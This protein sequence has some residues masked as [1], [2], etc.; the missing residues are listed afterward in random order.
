MTQL[1]IAGLVLLCLLSVGANAYL[2][3]TLARRRRA[4]EEED[5]S[6]QLPPPQG[7][8]NNS[9]RR[10]PALSQDTTQ[11][12]DAPSTM[13]EARDSTI[14]TGETLETIATGTTQEP[15][16]TSET[17]ETTATGDGA[18]VFDAPQSSEES[19][20]ATANVP[21]EVPAMVAATVPAAV[22][23]TAD[24]AVAA[25]DPCRVVN[26]LNVYA[27]AQAM[28]AHYQRSSR[29][30]ELRRHECFSK[31]VRLLLGNYYDTRDLIEFGR[32][33]NVVVACIALEALGER[34][35]GADAVE[36]ILAH[37]NEFYYWPG[38]YALRALDARAAERPVLVSLLLSIKGAWGDPT[39]LQ[40]LREF[41]ASRV[42]RGE[43]EAAFGD[44]LHTLPSDQVELL[45]TVF[46]ALKDVLPP[47]LTSEFESWKAA[48]VDLEFLRSFGRVWEFDAGSAASSNSGGGNTTGDEDAP[49]GIVLL[50]EVRERVLALETALR[51]EPPRSVLLVGDSG[52]GKT[53]LVRVLA[54]RLQRER[55]IILEASAADVM[56]GQQYIGQ[57]EGRVQTLVREIGG[58]RVLWVVPNF[59]EL[60]WAGRHQYNPTGLLDLLLPHIETGA[61]KLI[62][63]TPT[64][65]YEK[66]MQLRPK[67]RTSLETCRV[68]ALGDAETLEVARRWAESHET[69]SA[70][71]SVEKGARV[72]T[73]TTRADNADATN[74][75]TTTIAPPRI[76]AQTLQEAFQLAKQYLAD[77]A[78][79]GN[80]LLLLDSTRRRLLIERG[81]TNEAVVA[82]SDETQDEVTLDDLLVTLSQLTGLPVSI[83]DDREGLDLKELRG[84]FETRVL[85]QPEA[86]ECLVERV[87]MIKAG[88]TDPTRPQGV[89]LFVGPT[90]TGKTEIAKTLAEFLF[91]SPERMIRL[92]MSEFQTPETLDRILGEQ[93]EA[94]DSTALVNSIRKQPF[95]VVLLDEFEKAHPQVWD[96][97]LQVFD[98]GRLTDRR[99]NTAD[100]RHCVVI[101]TSNL[102]ATLPHG[103]SI[104]FSQEAQAQFAAGAVE[105]AVMRAFRR[106][107]VN[108]IDRVV[109]F[110]PL[111][112]AVMRDL[113]RK[114]LNDV[115][116]RR[117]L[118]TRQWAVEW[119]ESAID[120]LLEKGFT[121]DL[122]ARPLKR[123]I[124][125]YLLSPLALTIVNHQFPEGDQFLFVHA[126][127][128]QTLDVEFI[129]PDAPDEPAAI[130]SA[131]ADDALEDD[132]TEDAERELRLES[133]VLDARGTAEEVRFLRDRFDALADEVEADDWQAR[134]NSALLETAAPG[135]W[136]S[137]E[138]F[139]VLGLAEYMDRIE[140]G[141]DTAGSLLRR[142]GGSGGAA[143]DRQHFPV[144][145][146]A[147]LA[148]QLYLIDAACRGLAA[149][150]PRDL[151]LEVR[152]SCDAGADNAVC[153]DFARR[154][155]GM[156]RGWTAARRMR[157]EVLEETPPAAKDDGE[158][159][160]I[161]P[162]Q[163][164][165]AI[166]GFAAYSL[167]HT[168]AG[169]H[170]LETPQDEKSF[171]RARVHVRVVAQPDEPAG[172]GADALRKQA[173][174]A[175]AADANNS[176]QIVRR[177]REEPSP[178]VRDSLRGWRTGK[179]ERVLEGHFDLMF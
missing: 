45:T 115:L 60:V 172:H 118:R 179:L 32:D 23:A 88:L 107:F 138:R 149:G 112:R 29:P 129:D 121:A 70:R 16:A 47:K 108:R 43:R 71:S 120:F 17:Q 76:S 1:I 127:G 148:Q 56:A 167:L 119:D 175:F 174:R 74:N 177:Y 25:S 122:G 146:V 34:T 12:T 65:A 176:Q 103:A 82:S 160:A 94:A 102:G 158:S 13:R 53:A 4:P 116:R 81:M 3:R 48:R 83:L 86:V 49:E 154:I 152:A 19:I 157:F 97:F 178:L 10:E 20:A 163:L 106:E 166:S 50:A 136:N 151:F 2:A 171:N 144:E 147:R 150:H 95:A 134:K 67:L 28:D 78:A 57:L 135:F 90:G 18:H 35:D 170:V 26:E 113:L 55:W 61:L 104:G 140:T 15:N 153:N 75:N 92:D 161:E 91:G 63:E 46:D 33:T 142:L 98:D 64:A 68:S 36:Q 168:E 41:V 38:Y 165:A 69:A 124:E 84:F 11:T 30:A 87:A 62:G 8:K 155:A 21:T 58:K 51:K 117:G 111:G 80:L 159:G 132:A 169:L 22:A 110:R 96:L 164:T 85:G 52:V 100:F 5:A 99:G 133:I 130:T 93:S 125:R 77:K 128:G 101:M 73:E 40:S 123:A 109:V 66:L 27:F 14:A 105:R 7:A 72:S 44:A 39:P 145:L 126:R 143:R 37:I 54:R 114:E 137:P 42:E 139:S 6:A 24:E 59:H 89:F 131:T 79:P 31:G 141:L 162:Y 156:Y 9:A 173:A